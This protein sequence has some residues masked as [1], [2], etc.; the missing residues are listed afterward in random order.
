MESDSDWE[1]LISSM[2]PKTLEFND[3]NLNFHDEDEGPKGESLF[4]ALCC[5]VENIDQSQADENK[6]YH[7]IFC[8][9]PTCTSPMTQDV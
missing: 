8:S 2:G 9:D 1:E 4:E 5:S 3:D 7:S 6:I